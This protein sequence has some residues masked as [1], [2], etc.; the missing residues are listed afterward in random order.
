MSLYLARPDRFLVLQCARLCEL[1]TR[2]AWHF[3]DLGRRDLATNY[4]RVAR[5]YSHRAFQVVRSQGV[6]LGR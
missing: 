4:R 2:V 6:H 5:F 1:A 3:H